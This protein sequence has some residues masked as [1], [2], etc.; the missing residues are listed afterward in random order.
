MMGQFHF[1][2]WNIV[3]DLLIDPSAVCCDWHLPTVTSLVLRLKVHLQSVHGP[4]WVLW[5]LA[6]CS[7]FTILT[8]F[9]YWIASTACHFY[10]LT[11]ISSKIVL[12]SARAPGLFNITLL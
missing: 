9:L 3:Y 12:L 6:M 11:A 5:R 10:T 1:K 4:S 2:D 7:V 8:A